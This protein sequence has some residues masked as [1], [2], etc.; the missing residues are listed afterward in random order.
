MRKF[1]LISVILQ[2]DASL[3]A[4]SDQASCFATDTYFQLLACNSYTL[5]KLVATATRD[6]PDIESHHCATGT[7]AV[8]RIVAKVC[9]HLALILV[10]TTTASFRSF[11]FIFIN[12]VAP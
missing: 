5:F 6:M 12:R 3:L 1:W 10:D 2:C 4:A 8:L 7:V 11:L 9:L